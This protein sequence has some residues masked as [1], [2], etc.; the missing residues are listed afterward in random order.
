MKHC[1]LLFIYARKINLPKLTSIKAEASLT[2]TMNTLPDAV[3]FNLT[4][5][6]E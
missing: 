2:M 3:V 6:V 1:T 5:L 4:A